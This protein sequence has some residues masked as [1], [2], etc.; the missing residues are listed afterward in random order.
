MQGGGRDGAHILAGRTTQIFVTPITLERVRERLAGYRPRRLSAAGW[1]EA[2][3]ALLLAPGTDRR[4]EL[5]LI[6]RAEHPGDPWSGQMALP[7]GRRDPGDLD[8]FATVIR[9]TWEEV[10]I[11][12]GGEELLGELDDLAPRTPTLPPVVVR[13]FVFG[14]RAKPAVSPSREVA[15]HIWVALDELASGQTRTQI[16]I[17]SRRESFPGYRVGVHVVWGM[18]ERILR[19]FIELVK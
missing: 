19:P 15:E 12:V 5:L 16:T 3:V 4:V 1:V 14:L 17:P 11:R 9:E 10:G 2:A 7:G 8:W 13:P 18:T 6:R